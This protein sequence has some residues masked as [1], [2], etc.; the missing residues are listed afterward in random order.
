MLRYRWRLPH[1][2][3][4]CLQKELSGAGKKV[5]FFPV[6]R[7][8]IQILEQGAVTRFKIDVRETLRNE[9]VK[10]F[11]LRHTQLSFSLKEVT[12]MPINV[13]F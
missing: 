1:L 10:D 13:D 2:C 3:A 5:A 8:G 9:S 7:G 12:E 6:Q 11:K 4:S